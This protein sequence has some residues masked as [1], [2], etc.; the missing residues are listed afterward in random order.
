VPIPGVVAPETP[1]VE[2]SADPV[3]VAGPSNG[4]HN[5]GRFLRRVRSRAVLLPLACVGALAV[6]FGT[7]TAV[8]ELGDTPAKSDT[9]TPATTVAPGT[10]PVPA[11]TAAP[12]APR[13]PVPTTEVPEAAREVPSPSPPPTPQPA[14]PAEAKSP[15]PVTS[16]PPTTTAPTTPPST[17]APSTTTPGIEAQIDER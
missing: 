7:V 5:Q 16:A 8:L 17:T 9:D 10:Q 6:G 14:P 1:V 2:E 15:A 3:T 13:S 4:A 12:V 11:P